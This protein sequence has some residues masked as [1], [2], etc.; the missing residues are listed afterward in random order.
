MNATELTAFQTHRDARASEILAALV[1]KARARS[2]RLI[3]E[4][5]PDD[6]G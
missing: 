6:T 1:R 4:H 5:P 3:G 2:Q